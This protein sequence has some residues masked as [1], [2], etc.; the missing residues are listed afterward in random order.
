MEITKFEY[1]GWTNSYK[2]ANNKVELIVLSDVGP[3]II[4]FGFV[5]ERNQ[6]VEFP[7]YSG[8]IEGNQWRIYG[9]HR[10]WHSPENIVRTY[11]PDNQ[12]VEV[13]LK[14]KGL[15]LVQQEEASTKLQ[16]KME[17]ELDSEASDVT[18]LHTIK[19]CSLWNIKL[20][21][22]AISAMAAGGLSILKQRTRE[23]EDVCTPNLRISVWPH[24]SIS[25]S[26]VTWGTEYILLRQDSNIQEKFKIGVSC[27]A[28]WL[29]YAN[30][31][32]IFVK[33]CEFDSMAEYPDFG[34]SMELY[35]CD[36]FSEI[37]TLS[38]MVEL[39]PGAEIVHK[40]V[41][42]LFKIDKTVEE[43]LDEKILN[44]QIKSVNEGGYK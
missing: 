24:T 10:L 14:E 3:R 1:K 41:W 19:N 9:G 2:I 25:D 20:S 35:T 16:K 40:E 30:D 37:E 43:L 12:K 17:I 8:L 22:W 31:K 39:A 13:V 29:A 38:P 18:V 23:S 28:G 32:N 11:Y 36:R 26:R 7:E 4:S 34:S 15:L 21:V 27:D 5:G 33:Y 42:R 6:F 44:S